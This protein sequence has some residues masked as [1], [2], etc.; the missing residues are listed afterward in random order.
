M[1]LRMKWY[2]RDISVTFIVVNH[3]SVLFI[4]FVG[5]QGLGT[6]LVLESNDILR[7]NSKCEVSEFR[8]TKICFLYNVG[9]SKRE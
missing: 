2:S 4:Y 7:E 6:I 5:L 8:L 3:Q 9:R 1:H